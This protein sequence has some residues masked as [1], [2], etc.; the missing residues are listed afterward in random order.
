MSS[1]RCYYEVLGVERTAS[2]EV[3]KGAYR[4]A[5]KE[6]HPDAELPAFYAK[7]ASRKSAQTC[8]RS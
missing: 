4:K 6:H 3:I 7:S 2:I 5:A 1:K 8:Q